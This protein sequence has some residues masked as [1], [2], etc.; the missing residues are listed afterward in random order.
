MIATVRDEEVGPDHPLSI[1]LGEIPAAS[2]VSITLRPLSASAVEVLSA[3]T[4]VDAEVLYRATAGNPFFVTEVLAAGGVRLPS[5]VRE[6]VW[7]RAKRLSPAALEVVRAASVLGPRCDAGI[8]SEVAGAGPSGIDD[9]VAGGVLRRQRS[10]VEFRH[11]LARGAVLESLLASERT[12]LHQ[13]ALWALRDTA[14]STEPGEL[15]RHA[16]EAG[17]VASILEHGPK[18]AAAAAALGSHGAAIVH[19][20]SALPHL[21]HL[22]GQGRRPCWRPTHTSAT[23]KAIVPWRWRRRKRPSHYGATAPIQ[24]PSGP[25]QATWLNTCGGTARPDA[26]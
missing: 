3:G 17:D 20:E 16:V 4:T 23:S 2:T 13:R 15:A 19:Y 7:A 21:Q 11:E 22:P 9:C 8:L 26:P 10:L 1:A 24:V 18:A 5:T 12:A 14:P 6:A 25:R